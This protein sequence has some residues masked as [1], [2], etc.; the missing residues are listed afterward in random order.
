M[1]PTHTKISVDDYGAKRRFEGK[2]QRQSSPYIKQ[3]LKRVTKQIN[4]ADYIIAHCPLI[5]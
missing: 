5:V 1:I 3:Y 2:N 4:S